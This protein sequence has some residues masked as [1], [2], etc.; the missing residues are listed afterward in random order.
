MKI[1]GIGRVKARALFRIGVTDLSSVRG[2]A[3]A[4]VVRAVGHASAEALKKKVGEDVTQ[5]KAQR[6]FG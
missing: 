5:L 1:R 6:R 2:V 4:E 3:F